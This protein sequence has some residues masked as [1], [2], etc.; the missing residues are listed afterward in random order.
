MEGTNGVSQARRYPVPWG[1]VLGLASHIRKGTRES[2]DR[3][4]EA[5]VSRIDPPPRIEGVENLPPSPRFV[6]T[7]NHFQRKGLW[8]L[9]PAAVLTQAIRRR[10]GA[11]DPPVR[12]IVTA[13]WPPLRIGPWRVPSPGDWLL[14]RVAHALWCYEVPFTGSDPARTARSLRRVLRDARS[15]GAPIG[16]F[17]EGVAGTAGIP[18][19]PLP[20]V[21]RLLAHLARAGLPAQPVGIREDSAL[22]FR[23]GRTIPPAELTAAPDAARLVMQRIGELMR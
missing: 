7:A 11:L 4:S 9:F 13:N 5:V 3:F 8:I 2:V 16:L 1:L 22:A 15:A 14:P 18:N 17:P 12:W 20:G 21:D 6:L 19:R 10:Y 23:I